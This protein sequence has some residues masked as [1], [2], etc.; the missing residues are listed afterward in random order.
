MTTTIDWTI[1]HKIRVTTTALTEVTGS[2]YC[3]DPLSQT[4]TLEESP[5]KFRIVRTPLIKSV[6]VLEKPKST[7][8]STPTAAA[9]TSAP[10]SKPKNSWS[11]IARAKKDAPPAVSTQAFETNSPVGFVDLDAVKR[12]EGDVVNQEMR[13]QANKGVG[14][15]EQGQEIYDAIAKTLPCR[16]DGKSI[17]AVEEVQI[18]PPYNTLSC[19]ANKPNSQALA[20]VK[21]IIEATWKK[22][23][24]RAK[25]G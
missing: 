8:G 25:G 22:I 10:A 18:D 2:V 7:P 4:V 9:A 21:K 20:H 15:T 1:G 23:D 17:L 19:K 6:V 14:V 5:Q 24:E 12:R 16:W 3:Y 11:E 13:K